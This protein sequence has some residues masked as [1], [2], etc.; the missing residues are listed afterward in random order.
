MINIENFEE[1][2][3]FGEIKNL[4]LL[5]K[6]TGSHLIKRMFIATSHPHYF[7]FSCKRIEDG[8][9]EAG[10][11]KMISLAVRG[12][13]LQKTEIKVPFKYVLEENIHKTSKNC[14][15]SEG[16]TIV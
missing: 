5:I 10:V 1:N 4:R 8:E 11:N 14:A 3:Y 9:I 6:N 12:S 13:F 2:I 16:F 15:S 7:G